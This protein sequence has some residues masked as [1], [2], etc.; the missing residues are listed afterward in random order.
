MPPRSIR[1]GAAVL[2]VVALVAAVKFF[3]LD[4]VV[5][6]G[7]SMLP[8]LKSG[9]VVLVL[10]CAY[11]IKNPLGAGY[12]SRWAS[13][14][15]GEIVAAASPRDGRVVVKRVAAV[16]PAALSVAAGRL[17]GPAVDVPLAAD[18]AARLGDAA[19]IPRG[20]VFLLGDNDAES[21]DSRDYGPVP[22]DALYGRALAGSRR[23]AQ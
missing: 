19:S 3:V 14:K 21:V 18:A 11:G 16:G 12:L 13:P 4:A 15:R 20:T 10:R 5:V 8:L 2:A 22:V 23:S 1:P 17:V 6:D 9:S 7:R